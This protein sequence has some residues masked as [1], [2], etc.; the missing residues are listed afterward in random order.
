MEILDKTQN[1]ERISHIVGTLI[2]G[3]DTEKVNL[4]TFYK[5]C[6]MFHKYLKKNLNVDVIILVL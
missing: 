1:L 6:I 5:Q 3:I 4:E 2:M